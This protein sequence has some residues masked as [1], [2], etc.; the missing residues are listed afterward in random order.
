MTTETAK[1]PTANATDG[2]APESLS[3][4]NDLWSEFIKF[5]WENVIV[6]ALEHLSWPVVTLIIALTFKS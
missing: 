2:A 1:P 6:A 5:D 4:L 3:M